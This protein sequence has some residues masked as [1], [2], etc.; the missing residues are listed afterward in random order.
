MSILQRIAHPAR[1][2][3]APPLPS[4]RREVCLLSA[5]LSAEPGEA[6]AVAGRD[7]QAVAS[8]PVAHAEGRHYWHLTPA[9]QSVA[10]A[11]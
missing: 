7:Y 8:A 5:P 4:S 6:V 2:G 3:L 9:G 1:H 11:S 10:S